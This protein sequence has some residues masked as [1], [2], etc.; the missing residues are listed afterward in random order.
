MAPRKPGYLGRE[1]I[2]WKKD[3]ENREKVIE[4]AKKMKIFALFSKIYQ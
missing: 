3:R 1:F 2:K 4:I